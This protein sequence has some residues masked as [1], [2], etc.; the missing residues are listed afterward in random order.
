MNKNYARWVLQHRTLVIFF[1]LLLVAVM[2]GGIP[3]LQFSI[4]YE[5]FFG[6][7]NPELQAYE[8]IKA[9]YTDTDNLVFIVVPNQGDV[10]SVE[11]LTVVEKLTEK[12]WM[13]PYVN[14]VDSIT[15]FQYTYADNQGEDLVV[16]SLV[17]DAINLDADAISHV[18]KIALTE[19]SLIDFI[20]ASDGSA[21]SVVATFNLPNKSPQVI[22]ELVAVAKATISELHSEYPNVEIKPIGLTMLSYTYGQASRQD[23]KQLTPLMF[24]LVLFLVALLTRSIW[25]TV[26]SMIVIVMTGLAAFGVFGW[27]NIPITTVTAVAPTIIM[28]IVVAHCVH[29]IETFMQQWQE[30]RTKKEALE[31][32]VEM[33]LIPIYITS[34]TTLIGFLAMNFNDVPPY[35]DLGNL[36]AIAVFIAFL[37]SLSFLP[38]CLSLLPTQQRKTQSRHSRLG[39]MGGWV[40]DHRFFVMLSSAAI[41]IGAVWLV[42]Q[43]TLNEKFVEQFDERFE[44]RRNSDFYTDNVSGIYSIEYSIQAPGEGELKAASPKAL[45]QVDRFVQWLRVQSEIRHVYSI[46]DTF[47]RLNRNMHNDADAWYQL[48]SDPQLAAQYLLL[49]E[50]SLPFGLDVNNQLT[51]NKDATRVQVR[52]DDM[53][54]SEMLRMENRIMDWWQQHAPGY[55]VTGASTTTMFTHI[56][57]RAVDSMVSGTLLAFVLISVV[58]IVSLR[59]LKLGLLSLVPNIAPIIIGLGAWAILDGEIGMSFAVV[60]VLTLGIIV[61]DTVHFLSKY[62]FARKRLK[63][64][65]RAAIQQTFSTVGVALCITSLALVGGFGV[66]SLSGFAR[67]SDMGLMAAMTVGI[68]LLVDLLLLPAL[69]MVV[70]QPLSNAAQGTTQ[71][72][73]RDTNTTQIQEI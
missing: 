26:L 40:V 23:I 20:Q 42:P 51:L 52:F 31:L 29:I 37:L 28:A 11:S 67:N 60:V 5:Y 63:L 17:E 70:E 47:K 19:P 21:T 41:F 62:Q 64:D 6:P 39:K 65:P 2:A 13:L 16:A 48:P 24:L 7:D 57:K 15:N 58:M 22:A 72:T 55:E 69:L 43:N 12:A 35:R 30:G 53:P 73:N 3:R 46:T 1:T 4:D 25:G 33:N 18:Q 56:V 45:A 34:L 10:F 50:M 44:F 38:V 14:R 36:V 66:L 68:A 32:A 49:Y 71:D 27:L 9:A 8:K 54:S 59:S 61:D